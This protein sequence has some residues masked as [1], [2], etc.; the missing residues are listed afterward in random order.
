MLICERALWLV[1]LFLGEMLIAT[2]M[3]FFQ[4]E[5][6]RAVAAAI[7]FLRIAGWSL[8]TN[9]IYSSVGALL[10]RGTLLQ[11]HRHGAK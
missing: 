5:I 3:G 11:A 2:A 10:L 8:F 6:A 1:V 4:E 9:L 7:G